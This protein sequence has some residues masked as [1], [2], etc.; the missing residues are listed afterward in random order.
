MQLKR[1]R[2]GGEK[3]GVAAQGTRIIFLLGSAFEG[4]SILSSCG[5][6]PILISWASIDAVLRLILGPGYA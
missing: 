1:G 5:L 4:F 6:T 2:E 3:Q